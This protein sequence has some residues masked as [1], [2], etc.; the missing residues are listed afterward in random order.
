LWTVLQAFNPEVASVELAV[1]G[2]R[3]YWFWW[4]APLVVASA[5]TDPGDQR[6]AVV[7]L[8]VYSILIAVYAGIQFS[9]PASDPLNA[10]AAADA[11]AIATVST[12]GR[13]RVT[14]TFSYISGFSDFVTMAPALLFALGLGADG[15]WTRRL[16]AAGASFCAIAMPMS[17]TRAAVLAGGAGIAL[18]AWGAGLLGT[19]AGRRMVAA[20]A[21]AAAA[22]LWFAPDAVQ[23]VS[24]RFDTSE[25]RERFEAAVEYIPPL[26]MALVEYPVFGMGT[27]MMQNAAQMAGVRRRFMT[28]YEPGRYL[29]EL[30]AP[31]YLLF[32]AVR[33]GLAIALLRAGRNLKRLGRRAEAGG[34]YA[35]AGFAMV[36]N[37]VFDHVWQALFFVGVGLIL[38]AHTSAVS[39]RAA[40]RPR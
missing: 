26:A 16:A 15:A 21:V 34:A 32:S 37:L 31:G 39:K 23:G 19:R 13:V 4:I 8:S 30:G 20:G 17:G 12:T 9:L 7:I 36:G 28:E 14:S 33:I 25:T 24:D 22:A 27:G 18:V 2:L 11:N 35:F 38:N 3:S 40:D 29:L 6:R 5:I 10:Y 1:L